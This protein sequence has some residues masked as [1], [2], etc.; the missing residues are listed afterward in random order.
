MSLAHFVTEAK[1]NTPT[2][3]KTSVIEGRTTIAASDEKPAFERKDLKR[4]MA[5]ISD[6]NKAAAE[7]NKA[8]A[9]TWQSCQYLKN[10]SGKEMCTQY[11]AICAKEKC[12]KELM[13]KDFFEY[14]KYLKHGKSIK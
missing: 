2:L 13:E 4:T 12:K 6:G 7:A 5:V 14:K 10:F 8:R 3:G 1:R 11:M 9:S